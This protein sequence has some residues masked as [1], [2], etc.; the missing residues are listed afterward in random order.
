MPLIHLYGVQKSRMEKN[1]FINCNTGNILITYE[2]V[3]RA[4]HRLKNNQLI[5]SGRIR[6]NEYV[7]EENK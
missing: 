2:D 6:K 1:Q 4:M 7:R 5:N 3:V